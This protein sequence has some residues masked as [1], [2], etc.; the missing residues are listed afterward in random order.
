M[1]PELWDNHPVGY[2]RRQQHLEKWMRGGWLGW[3][4]KVA[5]NRSSSDCCGQKE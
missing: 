3:L 1:I 4:W 2:G 5:M